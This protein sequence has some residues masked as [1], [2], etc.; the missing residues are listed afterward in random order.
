[1]ASGILY[2]LIGFC[3]SWVTMKYRLKKVLTKADSE[4]EF[5]ILFFLGIVFWPC[6][7]FMWIM[8]FLGKLVKRFI[9]GKDEE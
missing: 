8:Y 5:G 4:V 6:V 3:V 9:M 7:A 2:L 1:M